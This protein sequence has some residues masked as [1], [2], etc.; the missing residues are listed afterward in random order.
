MTAAPRAA[1]D[2]CN[3]ANSDA[4]VRVIFHEVNQGV[5]GA[6]LTGVEAALRD[7]LDIV[8]KIDGDGQ[9]DPALLPLFVRPIADGAADITKGNRF[10]D[11]DGVRTMPLARLIGNAALSFSPS[12]LPVTGIFSTQPTG[13][14][15]WTCVCS[16]HSRGKS[17]RR[18]TSSSQIFCFA[19]GSPAQ[20][21]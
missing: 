4:R 18:D 6:V 14:S 11:P 2:L 7:K 20:R 15:P 12:S 10:H 13:T 19:P 16:R 1:A 9:M 5:G 8:V 21:Y 17:S 3:T